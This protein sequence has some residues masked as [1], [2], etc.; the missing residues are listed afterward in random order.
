MNKLETYL[1]KLTIDQ[2]TW[3]VTTALSVGTLP[4]VI[5]DFYFNPPPPVH[6]THYPTFGNLLAVWYCGAMAYVLF[7]GFVMASY[8]AMTKLI[9]FIMGGKWKILSNQRPQ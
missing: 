1:Q 6:F 7:Y 8:K 5:K 2:L 3:G 4:L 9:G